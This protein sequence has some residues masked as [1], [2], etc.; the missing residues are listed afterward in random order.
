MLSLL[1]LFSNTK[2]HRWR[3]KENHTVDRV[4]LPTFL[5]CGVFVC[6]WL[7]IELDQGYVCLSVC[8]FFSQCLKQYVE[9]LIKEGLET[10][11]SCPDSACPKRGHLQENEVLIKGKNSD[12]SDWLPISELPLLLLRL[13]NIY[14][15]AQISQDSMLI[16][17]AISRNNSHSIF[18]I[19]NF[20][21]CLH[22]QL[23]YEH[24]ISSTCRTGD[25]CAGKRAK[26]RDVSA[27]QINFFHFMNLLSR[28]SF[29]LPRNKHELAKLTCVQLV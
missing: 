18:I 13:M 14:N 29:P 2:T 1:P 10:A 8:L 5:I 17:V 22:N 11:I 28:R 20:V 15:N 6:G 21:S 9:L 7:D 12:F 16:T 26:N 24:F 23:L 25:A 19:Q 4:C 27:P 3:S